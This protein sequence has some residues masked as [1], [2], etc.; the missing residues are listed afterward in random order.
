MRTA[1]PILFSCHEALRERGAAALED[2]ES[3]A[4]LRRT[5]MWIERLFALLAHR[6]RARRSRYL[7]TRK[8]GLQAAWTAVVVNLHPI[9]AA[10]RAQG[11]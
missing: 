8:A 3:A 5:R 4:Y 10:L 7:G 11:A 2:P 6:Y 9:G 1:R